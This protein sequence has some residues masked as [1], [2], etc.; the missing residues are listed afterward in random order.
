MRFRALTVM[1][2]LVALLVPAGAAQAAATAPARDNWLATLNAYRATAGLSPVAA[3][4]A[5]VDGGT[6]H[7]RYMLATDDITHAED[8]SHPAYTAAGDEA[9][10]RG[11]VAMVWGGSAD[12]RRF[13]DMWMAGPFHA[14]GILDPRLTHSAYA[15]A[16]QG[17][18]RGVTAAVLDVI[19]GLDTSRP[20]PSD[21]IV[22]PG[23][24][25]GVPLGSYRGGEWPDP[26]TSC[27]NYQAPTG[28][29]IVIQFPR[30]TRVSSHRLA[31]DGGAVEHCVF[32][33]SSYRNP[34]KATERHAV[35]GL[36]ARNVVV[37]IPREP[38]P[39]GSTTTVSVTSR[40]TTATSTFRVT[41]GAFEP[42][43]TI[44]AEATPREP[45]P[46]PFDQAC[47]DARLERGAF[48]DVAV[49]ASHGPGIDC[50]AAW[51][52]AK[53]RTAT[54]FAPGQQVTRAQ[55]ATFLLRF[56]EAAGKPFSTGPRAF[57]DATASV[58]AH[59]IDALAAAGVV[60]GVGD[61][62][63]E[64]AAPVTRAQMATFLDRLWPQV[65]GEPLPDGKDAFAD[66]AGNPHESAINR[67]SAAGI[68]AGV[69]AQRF[70]PAGTVT[71][72]QMATF[73]ARSL[74]RLADSGIAT[75]PGR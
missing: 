12:A 3:R 9:G 28:L 11:N 7:A 8:P 63:Y 40:D 70:D 22:W 66:D 32:D 6:K 33:A 39:V 38:L 14:A 73:L 10:R 55:M 19:R 44:E 45:R 21:P 52:V 62:R 71:R 29:P 25:S 43:G 13:L 53:G 74:E 27:A 34:D 72:G 61:G 51:G 4:K 75:P 15:Q 30:D 69:R 24:G 67:M 59:A 26:L 68:A 60:R 47:P 16:S 5:W 23:D 64:P 18:D 17:G 37:V 36:A 54:T 2:L 35:K 50:V 65:A 48:A 57:R 49:D 56:A 41:D 20:G 31:T 46:S 58:H 42:A 1:A